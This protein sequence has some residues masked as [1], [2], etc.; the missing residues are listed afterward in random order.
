MKAI[1]ELIM[2]VKY[3]HL[4]ENV[5]L[6]NTVLQAVGVGYLTGHTLKFIEA[7]DFKNA[8]FAGVV[9]LGALVLGILSYQRARVD[10]KDE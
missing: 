6:A 7:G 9:D 4:K 3:S 10:P 2:E 1:S 5:Y 8:A